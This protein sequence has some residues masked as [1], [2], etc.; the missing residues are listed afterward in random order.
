MLRLIV[1]LLTLFVVVAPSGLAQEAPTPD[2]VYTGLYKISFGDIPQFMEDHNALSVPILDEMVQEGLLTAHNL[3]MHHTG[4]EYN[5]RLG[6]VVEEGINFEDVWAAFLGRAADRDPAAF[7]RTNR[8]IQSHMDEIWDIQFANWPSGE[9]TRY[10]YDAQ[11]QVNFADLQEW[12]RYWT[13]DVFPALDEAV[14]EGML[15]GYVVESHNTGGRF[16]WKILYLYDD[17]DVMDDLE[18]RLF[19][20]V[21]LDHPIWSMATAHRDELWQ[22]PPEG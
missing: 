10:V 5:L 18:A 6:L 15:Q 22:A 7:A 21:P 16:N 13:E 11:F 20:A 19:A 9:E 3:R 8:M 12:N 1:S 14:D 17:W 2:R 4:G